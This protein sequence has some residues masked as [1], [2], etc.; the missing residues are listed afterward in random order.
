MVMVMVRV[1][2]SPV[3]CFYK[4]MKSGADL[5]FKAADSPQLTVSCHYFQPNLQLLSQ[6]QNISA[7]S[8]V[9]RPPN[10]TASRQMYVCAN[11]VPGVVAWQ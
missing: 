10:S 3:F 6:P 11:N 5:G 2:V 7:L 9:S 8:L 1:R 4:I